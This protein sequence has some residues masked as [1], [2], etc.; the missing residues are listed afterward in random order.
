MEINAAQMKTMTNTEDVLEIELG[1]RRLEQVNSFV[2][3]GCRVAKD[4]SG[5]ARAR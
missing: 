3:L 2:Y 4:A 1:T 5:I